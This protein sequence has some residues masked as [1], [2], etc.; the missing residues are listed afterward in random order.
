[1]PPRIV[2]SILGNLCDKHIAVLGFPCQLDNIKLHQVSAIG[3]CRDLL[4]DGAVLSIHDHWV[5]LDVLESM[6]LS[7]PDGHALKGA[8]EKATTVEMACEGADA[9]LVLSDCPHYR[10][11]CWSELSARM[12]RPAWIVDARYGTDLTAAAA[13]GL[14]TWQLGWEQG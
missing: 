6:L 1:M 2:K 13:A 4:Q 14:E 12:R 11:L 7:V 8:F 5:E 10:D 9:V 3:I